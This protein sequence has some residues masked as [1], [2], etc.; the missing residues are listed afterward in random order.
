M[1]CKNP[2]RQ[3]FPTDS[4]VGIV[5]YLY[6]KTKKIPKISIN[7]NS[8]NILSN[9]SN[10]YLYGNESAFMFYTPRDS[11]PAITFDFGSFFSV[12][13]DHYF[14]GLIKGHSPPVLWD[15]R[16]SNNNRTW[17]NISNPP[18]NDSLC[19]NSSK[20]INN[21]CGDDSS[22]FISCKSNKRAF[23]YIQYRLLL[24]RYQYYFVPDNEFML[25]LNMLDFY[26]LLI[27][28]KSVYYIPR[29]RVPNIVLLLIFITS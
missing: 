24:D 1:G 5:T 29:K 18:L 25:R 14:F 8:Y 20:K 3:S 6:R 12:F 15:L 23:R 4:D 22:V 11:Y 26:G 28:K 16:G 9:A 2:L 17:V 19:T 7:S 21:Q 27:N 13:V 10:A